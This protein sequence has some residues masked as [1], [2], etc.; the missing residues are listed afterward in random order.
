MRC[1][2][3]ALRHCHSNEQ[4]LIRA[5]RDQAHVTHNSAL[6]DA[7]SEAVLRMLVAALR[8]QP[9]AA[10]REHALRLVARYPAYAFDRRPITNPSGWIVETLK[11]VFQGFFAHKSF[12]DT[13]LDVVNRGGDSDTTGAI[14]GMLA[15]ALHGARAI[16]GRWLGRLD[17]EVARDCR[18]Q[19]LQ[20]VRLATKAPA[21]AS[22]R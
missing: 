9:L 21:V 18:S 12:E 3:V 11:A 6:A 17:K 8:G 22:R 16:P 14:V 15:G 1:L 10:L 19:A 2:P 13:L 5:S 20:L 7:G 4:G